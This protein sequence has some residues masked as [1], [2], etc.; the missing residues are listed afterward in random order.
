MP[1]DFRMNVLLP[2]AV[3]LLASVLIGR[4]AVIRMDPDTITFVLFLVIT[5]VV[6]AIPV[7]VY[8]EY[9]GKI[10]EYFSR[11]RSRRATCVVIAEKRMKSRTMRQSRL[12]CLR[13]FRMRSKEKR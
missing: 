12:A 1:E 6:F 7:T 9:R 11:H 4:Y 10:E 2:G 8:M 13:I 3:W 5:L